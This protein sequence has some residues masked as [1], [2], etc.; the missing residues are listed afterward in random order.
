MNKI[1]KS[2][3]LALCCV[4]FISGCSNPEEKIYKNFFAKLDENKTNIYIKSDTTYFDYADNHFEYYISN[5]KEEYLIYKRDYVNN[6]IAYN[7]T[8]DTMISLPIDSDSTKAYC[9]LYNEEDSI[10]LND[11]KCTDN[12]VSLLFSE[13]TFITMSLKHF[14]EDNNVTKQDLITSLSLHYKKNINNK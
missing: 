13:S 3:I 4:L 14:F 1:L 8:K 9:I 12:D 6:L 5:D 2:I 10:G 7:I 11:I